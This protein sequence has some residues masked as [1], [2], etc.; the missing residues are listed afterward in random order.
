MAISEQALE[1]NVA[2]L[3]IDPAHAWLQRIYD[4]TAQNYRAQDEEHV[5]GHD[6][7]HVSK[8]LRHVSGSFDREIRALDLGC[9]TGRYFHC[10][11]NARELVGLDISQQMLDAARNPV[12]GQEISARKVTLKQGDLFSGEFPEGHFDLIYC[13]GVFGNGCAITA[14]ACAQ[15]WRWLARGGVWFFDAT[16]VSFLPWRAKIKKNI[17]ARIYSALPRFAKNAWVK[18]SGWPPF[19]GND[20]NGVRARLQNAGFIIDWITS[21]RSQLPAG[22]GYKL[23]VLCRKPE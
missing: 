8:I 3:S 23:E 9:G 14:R 10:V 16:D 17:A 21:R 13:V 22:A 15:I 1:A 20:L 6:Y 7:R 4:R 18:R 12:R 11:Q 19:F 5:S 2:G